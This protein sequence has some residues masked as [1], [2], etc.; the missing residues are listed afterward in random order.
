MGA[1]RLIALLLAAATLS[2]CLGQGADGGRRLREGRRVFITAGCGSCHTVASAHTRGRA[3][4]D[5]DTSEPLS[6]AQIRRQLD[7]GEGGMPSFRGRLTPH[8]QTAV[9]EFVFQTL[10][11]RR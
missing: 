9:T 5:F 7:R 11:R 8:Q 6:R 1:R 2:G 3:G 10:H 4:P